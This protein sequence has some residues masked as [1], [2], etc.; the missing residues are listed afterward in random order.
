MSKGCIVNA[1]KLLTG[2]SGADMI[3]DAVYGIIFYDWMWW[4]DYAYDN[5][6]IVSWIKLSY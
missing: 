1:T 4:L 3:L 6:L 5:D 2:V